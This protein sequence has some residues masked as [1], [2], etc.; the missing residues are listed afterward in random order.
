MNNIY[1]IPRY[2]SHECPT[3]HHAIHS[4]FRGPICN[5]MGI[6]IQNI[7]IVLLRLCYM[8][9]ILWCTYCVRVTQ[10]C[11]SCATPRCT[12]TPRVICMF[13]CVCVYVVNEST[14]PCN[15]KNFTAR[16]LDSGF[17]FRIQINTHEAS[18][19]FVGGLMR[20]FEACARLVIPKLTA[21]EGAMVR[22]CPVLSTKC[23]VSIEIVLVSLKLQ[24][25]LGGT[26]LS[27]PQ[28]SHPSLLHSTAL[29]HVSP[30]RHATIHP[31][32][33]TGSIS[34]WQISAGYGNSSSTQPRLHTRPSTA[35]NN[36][37]CYTHSQHLSMA[38]HH[39]RRVCL[40]F[41][42]QKG[43]SC[44]RTVHPGRDTFIDLNCFY[45]WKQ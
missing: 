34:A 13:V 16:F 26:N 9:V 40:S 8:S 23:G 29:A 4:A 19:T 37:P 43:K 5:V 17:T 10:W 7:S 28:S 30:A 38:N 12:L 27:G 31:A 3:I 25:A 21:A 22:V 35:N 36:T 14:T 20:H 24:R 18:I 15:A 44:P 41:L 39:Q 2:H 45:Y 1:V 32:E 33:R 11:R 6:P 42:L